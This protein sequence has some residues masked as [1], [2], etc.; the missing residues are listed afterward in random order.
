ML[1]AITHHPVSSS[2]SCLWLPAPV[3]SK[4]FHPGGGMQDEDAGCIPLL[5]SGFLQPAPRAE[6]V[7][8]AWPWLPNPD[9]NRAAVVKKSSTA[10]KVSL[11]L[12]VPT[13]ILRILLDLAREK[14]L[15]AKAAANAELMAR[16]GR[17]K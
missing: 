4:G 16:I 13:H 6:S 10:R 9:T 1:S 8:E 15:Q 11:S 2:S 17:R 5:P 14:E 3:L 7:R 12:D